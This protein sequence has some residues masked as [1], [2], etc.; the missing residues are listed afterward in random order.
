M[1]KNKEYIIFDWNGTLID[2]AF[3]FVD[4]LNVLLEKRHLEKIDLKK[5][6]ELFCF[7][8]KEFYKKIEVI[9]K[10]KK[11]QLLLRF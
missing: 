10:S 8:I 4:I 6:R 3:V 1:L 5:Y 9:I 11:C 7:P 2:D